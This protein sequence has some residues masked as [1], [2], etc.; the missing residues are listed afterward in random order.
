MQY[1]EKRGLVFLLTNILVCIAFVSLCFLPAHGS[2]PQPSKERVVM[3]TLLLVLLGSQISVRLIVI[4]VFAIIHK[5][6]TDEDTVDVD[7][8]MDDMVDLKASHT[9]FT[10]F[11]ICLVLSLVTQAIGMPLQVFFL[12]LGVA[13]MAYGILGDA[14][15]IVLYRRGV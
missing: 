13:M 14:R 4:I 8:E 2:E 3:A 11:M 10:A 15:K 7:D 1:Q 12:G 9:S 5:R 6:A